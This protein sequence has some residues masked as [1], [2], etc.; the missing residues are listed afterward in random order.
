MESFSEW[1]SPE[2]LAQIT[3]Y[4]VRVI[5]VLLLLFV[6]KIV[7]GWV[8]RL[9]VGGLQRAQFDRTL[10]TFFGNLARYA[11]LTLAVLA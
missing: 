2:M 5:G 7:A 1:L 10:T 11:I 8:S 6:A 9:V 4:G 3:D